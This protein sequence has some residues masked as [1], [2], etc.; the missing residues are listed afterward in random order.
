MS[1]TFGLFNSSIMGMAAQ[2]NA[3]ASIAENIANSNTVGYK[4]AST[5]FLTLLNG[6][7][8]SQEFGGGVTTINR[9][10]VSAQGALLSTTSSTDLAIHGSG[11]FAV[12]DD[13]GAIFLTRNGSFAPDAQGRLVNSAGY[14]LMG[15]PPDVDASTTN[16]LA[17]MSVVRIR[18]DK[19]FAAATTS[20]S[21]AANL[22][23]QAT[24]IDPSELPSTNSA[25]AQFTAKSSITVYDNLGTPVVLDIYFAKTA[26]GEW[27]MTA[28]DHADAAAGGGFP[29][30]SGPLATQTLT[31]S[32]T[33]GVL[34]SG[35]P[36]SI[37]V[38][39]GATMQ[40]DIGDV[41]QLGSDFS[42]QNVSVNGNA[43]SP[44]REVSISP[45]G[46]LNYQLENGQ[47]IPAYTIALADVNSPVNLT[48]VSGNVFAVN[49]Q[50]GQAF[51]GRAGTG[52]FGL[53][54]SAKLEASTVDLATELSAMIV[55]QRAFTANSQAFQVA[56][57]V[58]QVLNNLK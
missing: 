53:I 12:S 49:E 19:L 36:I 42:V 55:A 37:P 50:S 56:S 14:Y 11:F 40:L 18:N 57:E 48:S 17:N 52:G 34:L 46:T 5:H 7:Q 58:I 6:F 33:N 22:P 25:G 8:N 47:S 4:D 41:T 2:S 43:A 28:F 51:V 44:I 1:T 26:T 9:Y 30:S 29:Y 21:F 3:L 35:N 15:F 10:N 32:S 45:D 38:P 20:G 23:A 27:E 16:S 13:S 54:M 39:S 31:F 24:A